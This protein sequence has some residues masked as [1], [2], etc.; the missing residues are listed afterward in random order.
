MT[1][2]SDASNQSVSKLS[3][4]GPIPPQVPGNVT[5]VS[6]WAASPFIHLQAGVPVS[7]RS[8]SIHPSLAGTIADTSSGPGT[9]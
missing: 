8:S 2:D 5:T 7:L 1:Q 3:I 4:E 6:A 9:A